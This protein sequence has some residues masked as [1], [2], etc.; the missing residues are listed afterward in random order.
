MKKRLT[1]TYQVA[2]DATGK[3]PHPDHE[4]FLEEHAQACLAEMIQE[5]YREGQLFNSLRVTT[6]DEGEEVSRC[7]SATWQCLYE[8]VDDEMSEE[9]PAEVA[10]GDDEQPLEFNQ[11][12]DYSLKDGHP[13][14]WITV[15]DAASV[16]VRT[17]GE[18]VA[19]EIYPRNH[20]DGPSVVEACATIAEIDAVADATDDTTDQ[21]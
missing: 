12:T 19:V 9:G 4:E 18:A 1:I 13:S 11:D 15:L 14:C 2:D 21:E 6:G 10:P 7:Y 16:Y 17:D 20:E 5:G 8:V 3:A